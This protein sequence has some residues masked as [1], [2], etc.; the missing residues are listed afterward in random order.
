M[1][2]LGR[3]THKTIKDLKVTQ[4][5]TCL[6]KMIECLTNMQSEATAYK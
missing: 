5:R 1:E 4:F 6:N 2:H 3:Y